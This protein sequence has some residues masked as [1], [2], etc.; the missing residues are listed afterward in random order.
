VSDNPVVQRP[1]AFFG[2]VML[3]SVPP[4]EKIFDLS[5]SQPKLLGVVGNGLPV[6]NEDAKT[7]YLSTDDYNAAKEHAKRID[8]YNEIKPN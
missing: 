2:G 8:A 1:T 7:C 6:V 4:G 5:G 3:V